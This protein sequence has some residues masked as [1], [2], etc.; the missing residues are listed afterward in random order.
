MPNEF[1]RE[2]LSSTDIVEVVSR[3]IK[4]KKTGKNY[5]ACCPFHHEKTPSFSVS[6]DK[7]IYHCFGCHATGDV[8]TFLSEHEHM[9]F[10][11]AIEELANL[12]G[13]TVP[14]EKSDVTKD[15]D[16]EIDITQCYQAL[17]AANKY[18]RW[19]LK[20]ADNAKDVIEYI[21]G[22]EIS[23]QTAK[24]F[25][26]GYAPELWQGLYDVLSQKFSD[27]VL[28]AVGVVI[29]NE[30][31]RIYD[32]FR[33]R[34]TFPIYNRRGQIVGFG[35]R[36]ISSDKSQ[37]KYL[38]SPETPVFHKSQEL[39]GLYQLKQRE[40]PTK[41]IVVEGYMDVVGLYEAG[42]H[43]AVATL[44]TA[45]TEDH[46]KVLFR[47]VDRIILCFDGDKAGQ[48]AALRAFQIIMPLLSDTKEARFLLLPENE[49]PDSYVRKHSRAAFEALCDSALSTSEFFSYFITKDK[50]IDS[51]DDVAK[52]LSK[53]KEILTGIKDNAYLESIKN[54]LAQKLGMS[55]A[56]LDAFLK[57]TNNVQKSEHNNIVVRWQKLNI[58]H[59]TVVEKAL[60]YILMMPKGIDEVV[61]RNNTV[62]FAC[63]TEQHI[64]LLDAL[65]IIRQ[66]IGLTSAMLVQILTEKYE[67]FRQYFYQL[68]QLPV[69]LDE[70]LLI[71]EL[72]AMLDK[73]TKEASQSELELLI[74]KSKRTILTEAERH[75]LQKLLHKKEKT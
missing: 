7:Q 46:A 14:Y 54:T 60:A 43:H 30:Q 47:E 50:N 16:Q 62:L 19:Q 31:S 21:K 9:S 39:Y 40:K 68:M 12:K 34:L 23:G 22:R 29:Q 48:S 20:Y 52:I 38:N 44:G 69:E 65:N 5:M 41:I 49:D 24:Y 75:K 3:F 70:K 57:Y 61:Q 58:N 17:D 73:V 11:E 2:L 37:P 1:I 66:N 67:K 45:F 63:K 42:C 51:A 56:Q 59:L 15:R 6:P 4:L 26:I 10:I 13:M 71:D 27:K 55:F 28:S 36:I 32:R 53:A 64:I 18:F 72:I 33:G 74:S 25:Q 8:V 35:G